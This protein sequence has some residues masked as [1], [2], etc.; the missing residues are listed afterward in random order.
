[1]RRL[2]RRLNSTMP[3]DEA[4]A[5]LTDS[6]IIATLSGPISSSFNFLSLL[7]W[8]ATAYLISNAAC[9]PLS[10]KLTDIFSR[11]WGLVFSNF[12]FAIGTLICGLAQS[13]WVIVFGRII[14]GI[15]GGGL[16]SIATFVTSDLVPLRRRGA[17]QGQSSIR[18]R[19]GSKS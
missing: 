7:S 8:L 12:F 3:S 14:A 10:G 6:T 19:P 17:W 2:V 5:C 1:M 13:D 15:G 18:M 9:Q 11:R 4:Y 16:T